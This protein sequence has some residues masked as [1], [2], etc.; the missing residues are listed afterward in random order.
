MDN[1][2]AG[3]LAARHLLELGHSRIGFLNAA[4]SLYFDAYERVL[5]F[6][7][8]CVEFAV[9][10]D[11][12]LYFECSPDLYTS[13]DMWKKLAGPRRPT[14]VICMNDEVARGLIHGTSAGGVQCPEDLSVVGFDDS[15]FAHFI[16]PGLSSVRQP[17]DEVG[18]T[19]VEAVH[20]MLQAGTTAAAAKHDVNFQPELIVRGSTKQLRGGA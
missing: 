15:R 11:P 3:Y 8:A 1:V 12:D 16:Q 2:Q 19:C 10:F 6:K 9:P 18:T 7:K 13:A 20:S 5:G 14:A 4:R 17:L